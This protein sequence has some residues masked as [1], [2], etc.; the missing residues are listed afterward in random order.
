MAIKK[1]ILFPHKTVKKGLQRF[2]ISLQ[3]LFDSYIYFFT[4]RDISSNIAIKLAIIIDARI[5]HHFL[6]RFLT[7]NSEASVSTA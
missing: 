2:F 5:V 6:V 3:P 1:D 4:C 7:Y